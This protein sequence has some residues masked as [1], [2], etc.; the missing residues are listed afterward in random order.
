MAYILEHTRLMWCW[1][2]VAA[3]VLLAAVIAVS[4]VKLKKLRRE[5]EELESL[6]SA[7]AELPPIDEAKK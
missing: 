5:Q 4:A 1:Y 7:K 3:L 2:D 6:V